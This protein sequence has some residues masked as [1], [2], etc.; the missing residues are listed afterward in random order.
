MAK[1]PWQNQLTQLNQLDSHDTMRFLTMANGDETILKSALMFL[2]C[3]VGVPCI[4]YGT[5]VAMEGGH[6]PDNRRTFPWEQ[7]DNRADMVA[8]INTLTTLRLES[9]ALQSGSLQ[10]LYTKGDVLAFARVLGD[11]V[12]MCAVNRSAE[13]ATI[14]LPLW[15]T[16][17][18][19][20]CFR[21]LFDG[22]SVNVN[23]GEV[24]MTI[25]GKSAQILW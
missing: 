21:S 12:V 2:F 7:L 23:E 8:F 3:W 1:V 19:Q 4:Y 14:S 25:Q 22:Q 9:N 11:E 15:Q 18:A 16:G 10:W 24:T 17:T 20:T 6:D 5:E 13:P